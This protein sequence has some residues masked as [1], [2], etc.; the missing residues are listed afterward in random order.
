MRYMSNHAIN[1]LA[2]PAEVLPILIE[3]AVLFYFVLLPHG[4]T[5]RMAR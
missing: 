5:T 4:R 1:L 2:M 3:M